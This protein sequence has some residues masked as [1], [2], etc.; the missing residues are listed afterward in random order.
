VPC[1]FGTVQN[2]VNAGRP[3][4]AV[5]GAKFAASPANLGAGAP[6]GV[7]GGTTELLDGSLLTK[8]RAHFRSTGGRY[9]AR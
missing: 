7:S 1:Y 8:L 3:W 9:V 5:T 4:S 6:L 2:P